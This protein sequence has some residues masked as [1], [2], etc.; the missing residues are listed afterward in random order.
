MVPFLPPKVSQVARLSGNSTLFQILSR[1]FDIECRSSIDLLWL[2]ITLKT[3]VI[4]IYDRRLQ[5]FVSERSALI[6]FVWP[7]YQIKASYIGNDII[8]LEINALYEMSLIRF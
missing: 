8:P 7:V 1:Q 2:T 3:R 6:R 4:R 5:E